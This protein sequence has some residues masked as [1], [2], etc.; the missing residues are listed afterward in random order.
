MFRKLTREKQKLSID[1]CKK[2]L[3]SEKRGVL[4]LYGL[5][6]YPYGV[7]M[8]FLYNEKENT[9]FFHGGKH[10]H[11]YEAILKKPKVSFCTFDKGYQE[12][13]KWPYIVKSVVVF[14]KVAEITDRKKAMDL[15]R[16]FGYKY[17]SDDEYVEYEVREDGPHSLCLELKIEDMQGKLVREE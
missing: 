12:E 15:L 3:T 1:E 5:D 11:K 9:I 16:A 13:G 6:G 8:D 2:L 7:P 17:C 14:G 4:S 10:G